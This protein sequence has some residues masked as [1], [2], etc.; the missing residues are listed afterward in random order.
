M[1]VKFPGKKRYVTLE[2]PLTGSNS[3][4]KVFED[5]DKSAYKLVT[6]FMN[7]RSNL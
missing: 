7:C 2:W 6:M 1:G 4:S 5:C 3:E